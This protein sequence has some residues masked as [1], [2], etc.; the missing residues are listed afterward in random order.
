[1]PINRLILLMKSLS[2]R[3]EEAIEAGHSVTSLA[4]AAG[5]T[6]AAVSHWR[7]G[8]TKSLKAKSAA[9]LEKL[10]GWSSAWWATGKGDKAASVRPASP[11]IDWPFRAVERSRVASL[12]QHSLGMLEHAMLT[13][14]EKAEG[15]GGSNNN[16]NRRKPKA[17]AN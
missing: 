13:A 3:V 12:D 4:H 7:Q 17:S 8:R 1:M 6:S 9:G 5:T 14:I 11:T 10:T 15:L 2:Q 16:E